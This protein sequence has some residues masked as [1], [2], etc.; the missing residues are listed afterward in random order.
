MCATEEMPRNLDTVS[1]HFALTVLAN[2]G[3]RLNR[4]F[5]TIECMPRSGSFDEE[6]LVVFVTTDFA[7]YH[8]TLPS[9]FAM[10]LYGPFLH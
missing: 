1:N 3:H 8:G 5:E 9:A 7:M 4:A 2:R 6:G 10:C